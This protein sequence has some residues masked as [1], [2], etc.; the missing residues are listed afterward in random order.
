MRDQFN[1]ETNTLARISEFF[2]LEGSN[3]MSSACI[4]KVSFAVSFYILENILN[5]P[6]P[7]PIIVKNKE[8]KEVQ[9]P[10]TPM[11]RDSALVR[12]VLIITRLNLDNIIVL[13]PNNPALPRII[14]EDTKFSDVQA[15]I[16]QKNI[17]F[18]RIDINSQI[19]DPTQNITLI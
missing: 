4:G 3:F 12:A 16:K 6:K 7:I 1:V 2:A 13:G 14:L 19:E 15:F 9:I 10:Q 17:S 5:A 11:D 8:G 18:G